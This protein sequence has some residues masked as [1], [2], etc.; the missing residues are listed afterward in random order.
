LLRRP[1]VLL[2]CINQG[3][4]QL[5]LAVSHHIEQVLGLRL[6]QHHCQLIGGKAA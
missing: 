2:W 6:V 5:L 3:N 1:D 4:A